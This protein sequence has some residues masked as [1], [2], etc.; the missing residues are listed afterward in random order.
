MWGFVF[1]PPLIFTPAFR[2]FWLSHFSLPTVDGT[3]LLHKQRRGNWEAERD[4]QRQSVWGWST[5]PPPTDDFVPDWMG[6]KQ[7]V[8]SLDFR[9]WIIQECV[10]IRLN[11]I[12]VLCHAI[13]AEDCKW[14]W[15]RADALQHR[16][17]CFWTRWK[18]GGMESSSYPVQK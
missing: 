5:A 7:S 10:L 1:C 2:G 18:A 12:I 15:Q 17:R 6:L 9:Y 14:G 8:V 3:T 13:N 11:A 4:G 16:N